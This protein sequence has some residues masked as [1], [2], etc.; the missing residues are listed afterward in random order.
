[1]SKKIKPILIIIILLIAFRFWLLAS[2]NWNIITNSYYDSHLQINEAISL[3]RGTWLGA[4]SK[5]T[6]CKGI[7]YPFFLFVLNILHMPYYI[8]MGILITFASWLFTKAIEPICKNKIIRSIIFIFLLF[9]PIG[10]SKESLYHYRNALIPWVILIVISCIIGIYLRKKEKIK[11]MLPYGI[12]GF[13]STGFFWLLRED[14]IWF[15]PFV[16]GS[17]FFTII[18]F[19][20]EKNKLK[21]FIGKTIV[22]LCPT[23]GIIFFVLF[24]SALNYYVYGIFATNDRTS[25]YEAKTLGQLVLIDDGANLNNDVWVSDKAIELAKKASP[26]FKTLDLSP[27]DNWPRIGDYSIWALRDSVSNSGYYNDAKETNELYKKIYKELKEAFSKGKLKRKKAIKFSDTSGV[28]SKEEI[29][30]PIPIIFSSLYYH[31]TYKYDEVADEI[32][33]NYDDINSIEKYEVLLRINLLKK[34]STLYDNGADYDR[35]KENNNLRRTLKINKNVSNGIIFVYRVVGHII[36]FI[37][38]F[39]FVYSIIQL[40]R[41]KLNKEKGEILL[42]MTGLLLTTFINS[43]LVGLWGIG[44]KLNASDG[45]FNSYTTAQTILIVVFEILSIILLFEQIKKNKI[46]KRKIKC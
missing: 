14:S 41:K 12:I 20:Q 26:T 3:I 21:I 29:V 25:T 4:Y 37:S 19:I 13:I 44:F 15:L 11:E 6:L 36:L 23:L 16:L 45:L 28:Y 7:S 8:G 39:S 5:V 24:V 32:I 30:K 10:F 2:S 38:L 35:I 17:L 9:N 42:I 46:V 27:F 1:M 34:N 31:A 40:I 43:Y 18:Y 22:A 33:D